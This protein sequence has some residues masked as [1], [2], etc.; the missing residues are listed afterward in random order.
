[1]CNAHFQHHTAMLT[2]PSWAHGWIILSKLQFMRTS[3]NLTWFETPEFVC[4]VSGSFLEPTA[5][6]NAVVIACRAVLVES[7]NQGRLWHN[8]CQRV[9]IEWLDDIYIN[10]VRT[11]YTT[12][13]IYLSTNHS[14]AYN[15]QNRLSFHTIFV[16]RWQINHSQL[17]CKVSLLYTYI[18]VDMTSLVR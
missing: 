15:A 10:G 16:G 6:I 14:Q 17:G 13:K 12:A 18:H 2:E 5:D 11:R 4:G 7:V 9:H 8:P 1:M 3:E